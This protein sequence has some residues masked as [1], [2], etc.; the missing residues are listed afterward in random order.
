M[1]LDGLVLHAIVHE[2]QT[3]VGGR[4]NKI[5]Q[6]S[7]NDIILQ[8]R[9]QGQNVKLLL[10]ANPTYPRVQLTEQTSLNP[11]DA[12]MFCMLLRKHC[13]NG[14]IEAV[15]QIGMERV[16]RLQIRHRDELG[17][18][19]TKQILVEIMG[20]HS[21]IILLDPATD[22]I[23]DGIHHVTPAIS[24]YRIVM[25]GSKYVTPPAQDKQNPLEVDERTFRQV[26]DP[27][28]GEES[29]NSDKPEQRL[30]AA[31]SGLSPLI[32]KE[33][34]Y[35]SRQGGGSEEA[36]DLKALWQS[37]DSVMTAAR[38]HRDEPV[39]TEQKSTGKFFFAMTPLTHIEGES[40][41]Y[42]APSACLEA[43]YGD[44]AERDTVKQRVADLLRFLHNESNK[45]VKKL[46]KLQGT[47]DDSKDADKHR[48]LGELLTASLHDI[49]KGDRE[50]ETINYYDEDQALIKIP[51]DPLLSPS[52]NAQRYFKKYTKMKN[53]TAIVEEQIE[54]THQ[55]I[56]Y[57]NSLL[58][59]LSVASLTDIEEIRDELMEQGYIRDRNKKQRKKKKK[60]KPALACY[61]SS[62]QIPIYV[63][64]NNTQNEFLTN[65]LA[66]SS[67][68]WLHTKDIPGSH[69]VIRGDNYS[70]TTLREA[71][72][73]AAYF[74]QAKHS[75]QV[76]VDY[77]T[78]KHVHKPNGSK[79]GFVIYVN[80]KTLFVTPDEHEIKQMKVTIK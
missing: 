61:M 33:I 2:L 48:V 52:E 13:E 50:I 73:L 41:A 36:T 43:F 72:Q 54:Q 40:T 1:A 6:P 64:K 37:F 59:Q 66:A 16:I 27:A 63:G 57:L 30:V 9:A 75:S 44:K 70:E 80:Q 8:I 15:E 14:V 78:I 31:F 74:S 51:L 42:M 12:P 20:R 62:E 29:S 28:V 71:A 68:T 60:D 32:A 58:Q 77:T 79:P 21:N 23:L 5:H 35:R 38:E 56:A 26:M 10:S 7:E 67:D 46:E 47:V 18:M 11:L 4:I 49:K 76:P 24:S 3:C 34:V 25:P 45:N 39:I 69:V 55:E 17:D 65:R 22:T 19:S 53:S